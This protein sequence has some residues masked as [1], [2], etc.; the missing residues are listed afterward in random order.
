M[1]NKS[2][3]IINK[4][5]NKEKL[6]EKDKILLM[7]N[8]KLNLII[9]KLIRLIKEYENIYDTNDIELFKNHQLQYKS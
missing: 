5:L 3:L 7:L 6:N 4:I 2:K 8:P 9:K 1:D